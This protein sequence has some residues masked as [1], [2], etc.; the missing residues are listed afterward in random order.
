M[1]LRYPECTPPPGAMCRQ[2]AD[3]LQLYVR[4]DSSHIPTPDV[5]TMALIE[6][7][8]RPK[9]MTNPSL[10]FFIDVPHA[11]VSWMLVNLQTMVDVLKDA[12]E[13]LEHRLFT[14]V[15]P[16]KPPQDNQGQQPGQQN[17]D[18]SQQDSQHQRLGAFMI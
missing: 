8:D 17:L 13:G 16:V 2:L 15:I 18:E 3:M 11:C 4:L 14:S 9:M 7:A 1:Y 6:I 12:T 10:M 5:A